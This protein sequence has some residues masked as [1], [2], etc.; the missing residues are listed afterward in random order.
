MKRIKLLIILLVSGFF[1]QAQQAL[2]LT[3]AIAKSLENNCDIIIA[4]G[5]QQIAEINNN[6]GTAGR[7]PYINLSAGDNNSYTLNDGD[8]ATSV[9]LNAG[10]SLN[11]TIFDGFSVRINKTRLEELENL[12][13]NNTAIMVEGTIQSVILAYYDVLLQTRQGL[14]LLGHRQAPR[15]DVALRTSRV[16]P[17]RGRHQ[18]VSFRVSDRQRLRLLVR[19]PVA[20][21]WFSASPAS[22]R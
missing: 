22:F 4:K 12:S 15:L 19:T 2:T 20:A 16:Q 14:R 17:S 8:N 5:N 13:K 7:Y 6:W 3:D 21:E 18:E 9:R 10:A 1:V 11:W